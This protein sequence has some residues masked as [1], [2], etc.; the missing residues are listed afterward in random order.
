MMTSAG[1][2]VVVDG[3]TVV[4]KVEAGGELGFDQEARHQSWSYETLDK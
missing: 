2:E 1:E 3:A 4:V